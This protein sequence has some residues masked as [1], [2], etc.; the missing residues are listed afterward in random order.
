MHRGSSL[1]A[2]KTPEEVG[3]DLEDNLTP[4]QVTFTFLD[5]LRRFVSI[6]ALMGDQVSL[7]SSLHESH[8]GGLAY[9]AQYLPSTARNTTPYDTQRESTLAVAGHGNRVCGRR[10]CT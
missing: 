8:A 5:I 2:R 1:G 10:D 9:P 3:G 6:S 7:R 4:S